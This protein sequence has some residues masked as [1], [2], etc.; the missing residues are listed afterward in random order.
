MPGNTVG[1][2]FSEVLS[3][4]L[5][6]CCECF[7][8]IRSETVSRRFSSV[9]LLM[10]ISFFHQDV[11]Y[12]RKNFKRPDLQ[13]SPHQAFEQEVALLDTFFKGICKGGET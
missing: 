9:E 2:N 10:L 6:H 13:A 12:S 5:L 3:V 11:F 4:I 7:Q 8:I 1:N